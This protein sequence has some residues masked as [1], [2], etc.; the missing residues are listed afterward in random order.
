M[1]V[2]DQNGDDRLVGLLAAFSERLD[3]VH[4]RVDF[5]NA[6]RARNLG[7]SLARGDWLG[8]PDDDCE[9]LP[10]TLQSVELLSR[11][12]QVKVITGRTVDASGA[13]NVLRWK[14]NPV[15]FDRWTMFGCMTEATLFVR[16]EVFSAAGGFDPRFGPGARY[17]AAEGIDLM[18]RIFA[19]LG[20]GKAC[21]D[22]RVTMRHPSKIPPWNRW[23][24]AR[25]HDYA[26]GDGALIAKH[27]RPHMLYWGLRTLVA[28]T[29]QVMRCRGWLSLAFAARIAGLL[30]G[31]GSFCLTGWR[32]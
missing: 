21:Y 6:S 22:P 7:A 5:R 25:F 11:D 9:L 29:L 18:N 14:D 1:I 2:V 24:A 8:F 10:D 12:P 17:P 30:R 27:P 15:A 16:R 31:F 32:G 3:I 13:P 26:R 20:D 4:R 28:A 23:A 19:V